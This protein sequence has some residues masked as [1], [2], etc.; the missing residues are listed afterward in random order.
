[1]RRATAEEVIFELAELLLIYLEEL[2]EIKDS[3]EERFAY[4]EKTAYTEIA[5]MLQK[6]EQA[7]ECGLGFEIEERYPL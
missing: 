1:M 3:P 4:G 5:E 6:W 7:E 2:K